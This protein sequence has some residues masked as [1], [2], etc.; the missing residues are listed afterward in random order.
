MKNKAKLFLCGLALAMSGLLMPAQS[1]TIAAGADG[2]VQKKAKCPRRVAVLL[3]TV[4]PATFSEYRYLSGQ[5]QF[6]VIAVVSPIAGIVSEIKVDEGTLVDAGQELAVLN[7]DQDEKIKVLEQ[8]TEKKKE[9]LTARQNWKVKSERAIQTAEQDYQAALTL[10]EESRIL[11]NRIILAPLAGIARV[12]TVAGAEIAQETL[13]FEIVDT[14]H[15]RV[16]AALDADAAGFFNSGEKLMSAAEGFSGELEAEIVAVSKSQVGF[17]VNNSAG[18]LRE[19]MTINCKK[20]KAEHI[21]VIMLPASAIQHDGLGDFVYTADKKK[22]KK[23]YV[24]L[25]ASEAD[26]TMIE[27]GLVANTQL[28]VSGFE[29]LSDK[30]NI[31]IVNEAEM[32]GKKAGDQDKLK[33]QRAAAAEEAKIKGEEEKKTKAQAERKAKQAKAAAAAELK[34]KNEQEK[35]AKTAAAAE[36]KAKNKQEKQAKAA[37]AKAKKEEERK[38]RAL[39]KASACP[40]KVSV[41]T[42]LT[43]PETF[44]EYGYYTAPALPEAVVVASPP[45]SGW[46]FAL[47]VEEGSQVEQGGELLTLI[48]GD[49]EKIAKLRQEAV[50]KM[51]VLLD[52]Q[53]AKVKNEK[54]IQAAERDLQ[55]T[56]SLLEQEVAPFTH[57]ILAPVPGVVQNVKV[58]AGEDV[59]EAGSLMEILTESQLLVTIPLA[60][61][62]S[63]RFALDETVS[64]KVE[65]QDAASVAQVIAV[66]DTQVRLRVDN[67]GRQ[68]KTGSL[69]T[70]RKLKTE[71]ADAIAVQTKALL[72]DSLG[73][74]VYTADK[75]K[76]KKLYVTLGASEAG[77]TMIEKGLVANTQLIVSGFE[78]LS[79]KKKIRVVNEEQMANEKAEALA[80]QKVEKAEAEKKTAAQIRGIEEFIAHLEANRETLQYERYEKTKIN[81]QPVLKIFSGLETQKKLIELITQYAVKQITFELKDEQVISTITFKT[82]AQV[83]AKEEKPTV[84]EKVSL[85]GGRLRFAAHG[86]YYIMLDKNFKDAYV[87]LSGFGGSLA[88]RFASKIDFWVSGGLAAKNST[89][90][91]SSE[92]MKFRLIPLSAAVRYY[93]LEKGKLS[94]FAGAGP[95]VFM[96]KDVNPAG[97][98]KT[99]IVGFNALAGGYYQL[100][101]KVFAQL[102]L[103]FNLVRKDLY[104][105]STL[106]DPLNLSGL[107]LNLGVGIRL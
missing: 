81:K 26:K 11:A 37:A 66:G 48:T 83:A 50:R 62:D 60:A 74:F 89:P 25:G 45:V 75:K 4:K 6:D 32:L 96:V 40:K 70:V 51:K 35:Q 54:A 61:A 17:R 31:R 72:Q 53:G 88:F 1:D 23:L 5:G 46:I 38:A 19:G 36:L 104:P 41:L 99:T 7:A 55:K 10:L 82:A 92:E 42:E 15:L 95:N 49:S 12:K 2:T 27:K 106:D 73:D 13:M 93:L 67:S 9:I 100:S 65:G 107:E 69:F 29:C 43:Q 98:I 3:E 94:A 33:A 102:F 63:G 77:K 68:I 44:R 21:D 76:A 86:T 87:G 80:K 84:G 20:L 57:L 71:H 30:K 101:R 18:Q 97:D 91:W 85:F 79:D 22:A 56:Q 24:T 14:L 34:A 39:A 16:D 28:I 8:E 64:G 58:A 78:C 59:L 52:R 105:D 103:K 90:E 47:R